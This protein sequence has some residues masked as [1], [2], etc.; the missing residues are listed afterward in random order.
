MQ[1]EQHIKYVT[2]D[3]ARV[4]GG[5]NIMNTEEF[6][7]AEIFKKAELVFCEGWRTDRISTSEKASGKTNSL[8]ASHQYQ[9]QI[10]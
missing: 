2:K 7:M 5:Q 6:V 10:I 4:G 1:H 8:Q 3:M 9:E